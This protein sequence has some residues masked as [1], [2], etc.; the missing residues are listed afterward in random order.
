MVNKVAL[1]QVFFSQYSSLSPVSIILPVRSVLL[2]PKRQTDVAWNP[3]NQAALLWICGRITQKITFSLKSFLMCVHYLFLAFVY[4][5][6]CYMPV[7]LMPIR[8]RAVFWITHF[9]CGIA[10]S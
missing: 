4:M 6:L 2:V 3:S 1:G 10:R 5:R 8:Y 7:L 9:N